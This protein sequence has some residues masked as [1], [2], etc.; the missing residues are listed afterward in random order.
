[1]NCQSALSFVQY[2]IADYLG[3]TLK[4]ETCIFLKCKSTIFIVPTTAYFLLIMALSLRCTD[5]PLHPADSGILD[6]I[7]SPNLVQNLL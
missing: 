5:I 7:K 3:C 6:R 2:K 1:M 4:Y